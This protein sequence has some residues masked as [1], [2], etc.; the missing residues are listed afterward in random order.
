MGRDGPYR[1]GHTGFGP[2]QKKKIIHYKN[3]LRPSD[4]QFD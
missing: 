3:R 2:S 1:M 4:K